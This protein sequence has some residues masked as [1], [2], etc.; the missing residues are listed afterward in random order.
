MKRIWRDVKGYEGIYMVSNYGEVKSLDRFVRTK[1]NSVRKIKGAL[2]KQRTNVWGYYQVGLHFDGKIKLCSV[3]RLVA[4]AFPEICGEW[5]EGAEVNHKNEI[6]TDNRAENIEWCT[7]HYNINYGNRNNIVSLKNK[8][9]KTYMLA[10]EAHKKQVIKYDLNHNFIRVYNSIKEAS[11]EF[12]CSNPSTN[13][14]RCC[15]GKCKTAY[16]YIWEYKSEA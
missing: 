11:L 10:N 2:L 9:N 5:F 6:K 4:F 15:K 14:S 3:H 8:E 7:K 12:N 13:I 16:G 1:G